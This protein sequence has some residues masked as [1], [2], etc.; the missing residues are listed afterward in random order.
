MPSRS[1]SEHS[2]TTVEADGSAASYVL[3][4]FLANAATPGSLL[5]HVPIQPHILRRPPHRDDIDLPRALQIPTRQILH[6]HPALV[7]QLSLPALAHAIERLVD[8]HPTPLARLL[9]AIIAHA[10]D[11]FVAAV[12]VEVRA[13]DGMAPAQALVDDVPLPQSAFLLRRR[14][15]HHLVAVPR[16]D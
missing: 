1:G 6:P 4:A 7:D 2:A 3:P 9:A 10:D 8:A 16:L 13:P 11:Q 12:A 5:P 14:V 15:D